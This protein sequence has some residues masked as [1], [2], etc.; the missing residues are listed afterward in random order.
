MK[1]QEFHSGNLTRSSVLARDRTGIRQ[2]GNGLQAVLK[3]RLKDTVGPSFS[4]FRENFDVGST[5]IDRFCNNIAQ[6]LSIETEVSL[7]ESG[8]FIVP[9]ESISIIFQ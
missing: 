1:P 2:S 6:F 9:E 3:R 5:L 7:G 4:D 8:G